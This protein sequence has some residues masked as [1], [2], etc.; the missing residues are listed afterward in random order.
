MLCALDLLLAGPWGQMV[1][2]SVAQWAS[3]SAVWSVVVLVVLRADVTAG[4]MA[5]ALVGL[6]SGDGERSHGHYCEKC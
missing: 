1:A 4:L 5:V 6:L 2:R 3:E